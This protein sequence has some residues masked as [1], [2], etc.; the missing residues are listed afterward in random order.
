[1]C[2]RDSCYESGGAGI[3]CTVEDYSKVIDALANGGAGADGARILKPESIAKMSENRLNEQQ[4][5]DF[6]IGGKLEYGYGLGVRT[7]LDP[8]ASKSPLGEFGWDGAAGAYVLI[9]PVNHLS[10]FYV[11]AA[12]DSGTAFSDIH[13]TLRDLVYDSL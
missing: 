9:D 8:T 12:P 2:I 6:H 5:K 3:A 4:L 7:L 11:Q 10:L 13:P 1:M